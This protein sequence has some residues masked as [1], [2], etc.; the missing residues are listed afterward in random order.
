MN[1]HLAQS[2][3]IIQRAGA[4][5]ISPISSISSRSHLLLWRAALIGYTHEPSNPCVH[6]FLSR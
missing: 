6:L 5:S 2:Q 4:A 3:C 1:S